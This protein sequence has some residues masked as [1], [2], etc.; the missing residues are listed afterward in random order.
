DVAVDE[1][2]VEGGGAAEAAEEDAGAVDRLVPGDGAVA[3]P[4]DLVGPGVEEHAAAVVPGGVAGD[5]RAGEVHRGED[6]EESAT[7]HRRVVRQGAG[8]DGEGGQ[9][10]GRDAAAG[11]GLVLVEGARGDGHR[12]AVPVQVE[13]T[14]LPRGLVAGEGAGRDLDGGTVVGQVDDGGATAVGRV[15]EAPGD[16]LGGGDLV[17]HDRGGVVAAVDA[18]A[19]A[20]VVGGVVVEGAGGDGDLDDPVEVDAA[21]VPRDGLV[22]GEGAVGD[23]DRGALRDGEGA[24]VVVARVAGEGAAGEDERSGPDVDRTAR[25]SRLAAGEGAVDD[26][27]VDA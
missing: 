23:G 22:A 6:A 1:V 7:E 14:A 18:D 16:V 9:V 10:V 2:V 15:V 25:A 3:D 13:P 21:A 11:V 24:A 19:A 17:E 20:A 5:G 26:G 12:R 4:D 27:E 8:V